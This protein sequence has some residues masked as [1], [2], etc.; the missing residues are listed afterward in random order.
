M[1]NDVPCSIESTIE[2]GGV[3]RVKDLEN[4]ISG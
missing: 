2:L 4:A 3:R 1:A